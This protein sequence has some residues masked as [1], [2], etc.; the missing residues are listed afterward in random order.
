MEESN[1]IKH[2]VANSNQIMW[3][4]GAGTSRTAGMPTA[5]DL[6]WDLKLKYY[7]REENQDI[8][9]HDINNESIKA[10][11]QAFMQSKGF[12]ELWSAEEYSFYFELTFGDDY[13]EQQKYLIEQLNNNKI[14]LNIGH[15]ALAGLIGL[16]KAKILFTTNFDEVIEEALAKVT[17]RTI[18]AYHLEGS[19]GAL[20]ALNTERFPIYAKIHGDFKYR[21]LKNL[22]VDLI[23]NDKK[24]QECFLAAS[25]R[26]GLIVTGYSGRDKNVMSMFSQAIEQ[27]NAFPAGIFWTVPNLKGVI[28][29]VQT[30]INQA[31]EKGINAHI[32]ETGTFDSML[33]KI[34]RQLTDKGDF[35]GKIRTEKIKKV[36]IPLGQNG[37]GFP[38][39]RT[40][41][42]PIT[43]FPS[44]CA[45][46]KTKA[47]LSTAEVK[48]L[49]RK[50]HSR[51]IISRTD[52]ILAWGEEDEISKALGAENITSI[53]P[54]VLSEPKE[55]ISK[56]T[57]YHAFFE[58]ALTISLCDGRP[59]VLK[60]NRGFTLTV[61]SQKSNDT[62]FNP[63]RNA[64]KTNY[65]N[66]GKIDGIIP[67]SNFTRW[68]EGVSLKIE[69]KDDNAWLI[70]RPIIWIEPVA[71][72]KNSIDFIKKRKRY[73]Y[74]PI[75][76][77][78][79][80]AWITMLLG[81]VGNSDI[82]ITCFK[83]SQYS[84]VFKVN[85]RTAY[86]KK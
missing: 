57:G 52:E 33:S 22:A 66:I 34:W 32:V 39:L 65:D 51:A 83:D 81:G 41:A 42:L 30:F 60:N 31:Q 1:F 64:L 58:R 3:F 27:H 12:P 9:T 21:S 4:L 10:R 16:N 11:I 71:E 63:L 78:I 48:E 18:S 6:I 79:V 86:S 8:R 50:N 40:N 46:I 76:N 56:Y 54:Y 55:L 35:D 82:I 77:K 15:R 5:T 67:N 70:L 49:V 47:L 26:Y 75:T 61:D 13:F 29:E 45:L 44:N 43:E 2:F 19:Y 53:T 80:D 20:D 24:I 23:D 84:P 14:S 85:T 69:H 59:L 62:F 72:R 37:N 17:G 28:P 25:N 73:R 68:S 7:C 38:V 36:E 74:N